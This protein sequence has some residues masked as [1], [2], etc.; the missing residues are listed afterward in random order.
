MST[1]LDIQVRNALESRRGDWQRIADDAEVS[2]S[3]ISQF[4]RGKIPNPGFGTL[5]RLHS[6]LLLPSERSARER[7]KAA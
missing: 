4:V 1:E 5:K 6:A 2:H 7:A 3:W